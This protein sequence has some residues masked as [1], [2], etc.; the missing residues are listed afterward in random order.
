[1]PENVA[2]R[3]LEKACQMLF[4]HEINSHPNFLTSTFKSQES[5]TNV[6]ISDWI[7]TTFAKKY[8]KE[9]I[10][11]EKLKDF[12]VSDKEFYGLDSMKQD[13]M[14]IVEENLMDYVN[15]FEKYV[16]YCFISSYV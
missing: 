1:M 11:S 16:F 5:H 12:K 6:C 7:A 13:I 3:D 4:L 8:T 15:E 14:R 2:K 10:E 9:F